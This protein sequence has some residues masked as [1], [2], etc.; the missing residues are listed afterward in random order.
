M[1]CF[2]HATIHS[3]RPNGFTLVELMVVI[4]ITSVL[5][6]LLLPA[7]QSARESARK[8]E[9]KNN[10]KQLALACHN[11][12]DVH[13]HFPTG[14]WG[15]YWVGDA[16]RGFGRDQP[17]GWIFNLLPYFEQYTLYGQSSDGRPDVL[18]REQRVGA[19]EIT[20]TPLSIINCPSRRTNSLFPMTANEGGELGYFNS[21]TPHRAGRSDYAINSGDTYTEWPDGK[22]G[23]G[24]K[25]YDDA[26]LWSANHYWG[27]EQSVFFRYC[28]ADQTMTG[29][30]FERST[31]ATHHVEDGLSNT[32]LLGEKHIP[33][34]HYESGLDSGDNET[35]CTGFNNDNYRRTGRL[36]NGEI[37]ELLP[38]P[39]WAA[40][41]DR[42]GSFGSAHP[43]GWN[44][45][46][47]D[48]SVHTMAYDIDWHVHR[49]FGNRMDG[50]T[51]ERPQ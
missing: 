18:T 13:G 33:A 23:Q 38:T 20:Q 26:R 28:P 12:H 45:S 41:E 1:S 6:A 24:P 19:A 4:A 7:L 36:L 22:L 39:D 15:W 2:R 34:E 42:F 50:N 30:S 11:H 49:D 32:Y 14:G 44:V 46:F 16:D 31:I 37:R 3:A 5:V 51:L 21:I 8:V 48:G 29:I 17:G 43:T 9:C 35:W 10:I 40:I 47:C 27:G 25:S